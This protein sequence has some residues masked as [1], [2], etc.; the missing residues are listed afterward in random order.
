MTLN[1]LEKH[2]AQL[3]PEKLMEFRDWFLHFDGDRWDEKI[4]QDAGR[5]LR[6]HPQAV[7][8]GLCNW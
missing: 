3:P 7:F 2:V 5:N 1:E 6:G 4:D 8:P